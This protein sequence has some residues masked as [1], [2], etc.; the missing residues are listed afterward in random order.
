MF[1]RHA[2]TSG[3]VLSWLAEGGGTPVSNGSGEQ[4]QRGDGL[5]QKLCGV[6]CFRVSTEGACPVGEAIAFF[7]GL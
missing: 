1:R 4:C 2:K 3:V 6:Y 7:H 5:P